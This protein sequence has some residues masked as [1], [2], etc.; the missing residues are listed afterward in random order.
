[1][2]WAPDYA[3][4]AELK[5]YLRIEDSAD[6]VFVAAWITAVSRNVDDFCGRQ[7]GQ[8]EPEVRR[9]RSAWSATDSAYVADIDDVMDTDD[10]VVVDEA[11]TAVSF[12]LFPLNAAAKDR[13]YTRIHAGGCAELYITAPWGWS[14]LSSGP[15]A[16]KVGLFLQAARLAARRDAPFGVAGSP[17]E[18]SEVRLL[19][20]LDPDFRTALKPFRRKWWAR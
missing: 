6:D 19:A 13:P 12:E 16:A 4:S 18:G 20:Q 10:M 11:G 1:V 15:V 17:T 5:N 8:T 3:T 9:Y 2:P 14:P 7:F